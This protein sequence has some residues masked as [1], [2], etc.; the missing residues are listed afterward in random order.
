MCQ[1]YGFIGWLQFWGAML[2][3][4]VVA[5][6]FGYPPSQMLMIANTKIWLPNEG[7]SFNPSRIDFG[8]TGDDVQTAINKNECPDTSSFVMIDWLYTAHST[9][10]LRQAAL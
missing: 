8:N 3:Y 1:A 2:C 4:F 5:N 6:D 7:D 10:D 9:V